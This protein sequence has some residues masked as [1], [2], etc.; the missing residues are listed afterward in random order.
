MDPFTRK[1]TR[2]K[3][4]TSVRNINVNTPAA[5]GNADNDQLLTPGPQTGDVNEF[6]LCSWSQTLENQIDERIRRE[7]LTGGLSFPRFEGPSAVLLN[8]IGTVAG[9]VEVLVRP[10]P[11][12]PEPESETEIIEILISDDDLEFEEEREVQV[13]PEVE[14]EEI[15]DEDEDCEVVVENE[16]LV[17]EEFEIPVAASTP[18]LNVQEPDPEPYIPQPVLQVPEGYQE[19]F[20]RPLAREV[21]EPQPSTSRKWSTN[22]PP[23]SFHPYRRIEETPN[24]QRNHREHWKQYRE[25]GTAPVVPKVFGRV[26]EVLFSPPNYAAIGLTNQRPGE[27][28]KRQGFKIFPTEWIPMGSPYWLELIARMKFVPT[29]QKMMFRS[30][31]DG[32]FNHLIRYE[33]GRIVATR[34][35]TNVLIR[36]K[37]GDPEQVVAKALKRDEGSIRDNVIPTEFIPV[38][39]PYYA[40]LVGEM[41]FPLNK[42]IWVHTYARDNE[43]IQFHLGVKG[44]YVDVLRNGVTVRL[45]ERK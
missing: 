28:A 17:A 25:V 22:E 23:V 36:T 19:Y 8:N 16:P 4:V 26:N 43:N 44:E 21:E 10:E 13:S 6:S 42:D 18:I 7:S 37:H 41:F 2:A 34:N 33:N 45:F 24:Y 15:S 5:E 39:S 35:H 32:V 29:K 20:A 11:E 27:A 1:T 14:Y 9:D 30:I 31:Y 12:E 3:I 38:D 40:E